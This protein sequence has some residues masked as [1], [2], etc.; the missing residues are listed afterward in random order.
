MRKWVLALAVFESLYMLGAADLSYAQAQ[1]DPAPAVAER[2]MAALPMSFVPFAQ[3]EPEAANIAPP[4]TWEDNEDQ[5]VIAD[6]TATGMPRRLQ[7]KER[8][9]T[10]L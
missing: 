3:A 2:R 6:R 4:G 7:E 10:G 1:V 8:E 9:R 5:A